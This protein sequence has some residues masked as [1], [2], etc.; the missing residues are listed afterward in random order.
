M[1]IK[2]RIVF[3]TGTRADFGKLRPLLDV[4]NNSDDFECHIFVTGMHTLST[5]GFTY[6][7]VEKRGYK[8]IFVY[9]NQSENSNQDIILSNTIAGLSNFVNELSPDMIVIH[10]DRLEAL[11]GSTVGSLRNILV[12]HIE[13]G[14]V[15]GTRDESIRHAVSKLS[16]LHFV[17]NENAKK[18]LIQM[19]ERKNHIFII[20]SPDIDVMMSK[21]LPSI[22]ELRNYYEVPFEEYAIL[23][24]HPV[25]TELGYLEKQIDTVIASIIHSKK[26][27]VVIYPNNDPG[28]KI[29]L[30]AYKQL[31]NNNRFRMYPSL[32]FEYFLTLLKHADFIIGNS[33]AG[34]TE[35]GVYGVP[36][37]NIGSRQKNRTKNKNI[38]NV[39]NNQEEIQDAIEQIKGKK[40]DSSYDFGD[41]QSSKRF[42]GIISEDKV[43]DID[44]Q[45]YFVEMNNED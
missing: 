11:A 31:E 6:R 14:E 23:I 42:F 30:N 27:F 12:A 2:K 41:G 22:D 10:G 28:S 38:K 7:E 29:I 19:G 13:G 5:Y 17:S 3:V 8:N 24:F 34:I 25:T 15:T 39:Q 26:N 45:K 1:K 36:T 18:R 20:G 44:L 43:W 21:N 33:S 32:R 4:V 16:H 37:I 40:V 9:M 35:A